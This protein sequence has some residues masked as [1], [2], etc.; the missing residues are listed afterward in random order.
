YKNPLPISRIQYQ[1]KTNN[2]NRCYY[3]TEL[4]NLIL[5]QVDYKYQVHANTMELASIT[6]RANPKSTSLPPRHF[7]PKN[8]IP[9]GTSIY[10]FGTSTTQPKNEDN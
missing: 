7:T 3:I 10:Q 9:P 4:N 2:R 5:I 1:P 6:T 8:I